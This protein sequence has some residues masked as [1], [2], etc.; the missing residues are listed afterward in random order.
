MA[1]STQ[2]ST[3]RSSISAQKS[4]RRRRRSPHLDDDL[5]IEVPPLKELEIGHSWDSLQQ[6]KDGVK[7]WILDR[8]ESLLSNKDRL[9]L[10]SWSVVRRRR[11]GSIFESL[12]Q[13]RVLTKA[14]L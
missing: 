1:S 5:E 10:D 2:V 9:V 3:R 14:L 6:A 7:A 12:S 13:R 11:A 4:D 8:G